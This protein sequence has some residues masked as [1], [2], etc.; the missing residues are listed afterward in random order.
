MVYVVLTEN[1]IYR[2]YGTYFDT[3]MKQCTIHD[4]SYRTRYDGMI[5]R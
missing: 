2:T 5:V 4:I 3:G 1:I